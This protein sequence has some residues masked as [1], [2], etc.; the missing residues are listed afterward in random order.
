DVTMWW[1]AANLGVRAGVLAFGAHLGLQGAIAAWSLA[2]AGMWLVYG[3]CLA[4]LLRAGIG[5]FFGSW[6]RY[7]PLWGGLCGG[8]W[9]CQRAL[10]GDS[11]WA[12]AASALP[13]GIYLGAVWFLDREAAG[14]LLRLA[15]AR[16]DIPVDHDGPE[17]NPVNRSKC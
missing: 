9:L 6:L 3:L 8:W 2:S 4:W 11:V 17:S 16:R 7:V 10:G 12:L 14:L 5:R 15:G 13:A 1:N